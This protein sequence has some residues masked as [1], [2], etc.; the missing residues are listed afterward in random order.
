M[1]MRYFGGGI[2]HL[3]NTPPKQVPGFDPIDPSSEKLAV[4]EEGDDD[5]HCSGTNE[6]LGA[7]VQQPSRENNLNG[8]LEVG[9]DD[10]ND[11]DE[12]DD[13]DS[14]E[15]DEGGDQTD[16]D[17]DDESGRSGDEEEEGEDNYGYASP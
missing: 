13:E 9:D 15:G 10:E 6:D 5:N 3:K 1:V 12:D 2:G 7:I 11:T 14:D 16:E 17:E 4:E 8:E